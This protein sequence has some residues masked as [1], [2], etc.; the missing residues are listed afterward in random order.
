MVLDECDI[1]GGAETNMV[2][3]SP[4]LRSPNSTSAA[5]AN[6]ALSAKE[7]RAC[8]GTCEAVGYFLIQ[9]MSWMPLVLSLAGEGLL[10]YTAAFV[11]AWFNVLCISLI[12]YEMGKTYSWPKTLD[13]IFIVINGI[14]TF[15]TWTIPDNM[16]TINS[17]SNTMICGGIVIG[18]NVA[19]A[20]GY[21]FIKS[22][23]ADSVD[24]EGI[25]HPILKHMIRRL[26]DMWILTFSLMALISLIPP[27]ISIQD[28]SSGTVN[29]ICLMVMYVVL[30]LALCI[31][32]WLY[33]AYFVKHK[34]EIADL[35]LEEIQAWNK[36]HRNHKYARKDEEGGGLANIYE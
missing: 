23:V 28:G 24:E 30:A 25:S 4:L 2:D 20:L 21:P 11:A 36:E 31:S 16:T 10:A 19:W 6:K 22:H 15:L 14:L 3:E 33:P 29:T 8:D 35:Y 5:S 12:W 18:I 27:I 26:T 17:F 13:I 1:A 7:S 9:A 34:D 32:Y